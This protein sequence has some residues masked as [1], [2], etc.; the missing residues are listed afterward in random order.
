MCVRGWVGGLMCV[1][2]WEG[3]IK[4]IQI[5]RIVLL[6]LRLNVHGANKICEVRTSITALSELLTGMNVITLIT[7][8]F[9]CLL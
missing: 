5:Y 2:V 1:C 4:N 6:Y 7:L 3:G 9:N 8:C